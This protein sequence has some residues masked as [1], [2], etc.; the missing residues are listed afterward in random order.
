MDLQTILAQ[1]GIGNLDGWILT[2]AVD[3]SADGHAIVGNGFDPSGQFQAWIVTVPEPSMF[4]LALDSVRP[5]RHCP[6]LWLQS[7]AAQLFQP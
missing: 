4:A 3:V 5:V 1:R 6:P 2:D 7:T